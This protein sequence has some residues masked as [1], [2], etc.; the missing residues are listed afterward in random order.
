MQNILLY[1]ILPVTLGILVGAYCT[2]YIVFGL[3][4]ISVFA[5]VWGLMFFTR[6]GNGLAGIAGLMYA[7]PAFWCLV[8]LLGAFYVTTGQTF[9]QDALAHIR[10]QVFR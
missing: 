4:A 10:F 8:G 7:V 1:R 9:I 2:A 3:A 5:M 6:P